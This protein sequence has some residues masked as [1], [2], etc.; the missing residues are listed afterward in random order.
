[1]RSGSWVMLC[2]LLLKQHKSLLEHCRDE[3]SLMGFQKKKKRKGEK[4]KK[5]MLR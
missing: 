2:K 3:I 1:M 5:G 4:K